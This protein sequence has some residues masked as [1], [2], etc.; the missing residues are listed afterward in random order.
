MKEPSHHP[1]KE[2]WGSKSRHL[3]HVKIA[4][5]LT[6]S[7]AIYR[8]I[9][10]ARELIRRGATIYPVM[11]EEAAELLSPTLMEWATDSRTYVRFAGE[12]G[13]IGIGEEASAMLIAPATANIIGKLASSIADNAVTLTALN[14]MGKGK[15][16]I[17]VPAMHSGLWNSRPLQEALTKLENYWAIVIPPR[18]EEG[19][20]KYPNIEDIVDAADTLSTRGQDLKGLKILVTAG[21]TREWLDPVR[22]IS[23]PSTGRMGIALAREAHFR[24]ASVT[25]I[26]GPTAESL[27]HYIKTVRVETTEEMLNAVLQKARQ[28][29]PDAVIMAAAP[30]DFRPQE[31]VETKIESGKELM[32]KLIP[33]P[34]IASTLR[35]EYGGIIIGFA[36][37][38]ILNDEERLVSKAKDKLRKR[39]FNAIIANEVSYDKVGFAAEHSKAYLITE[40]G[41]VLRI[42]KGLKIVIARK[43]L[44][45]VKEEASK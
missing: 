33:T 2:I 30:A 13:H 29:K 38:T 15:P 40:E 8:T 21:P 17:L 23:N 27:P 28:V 36:A 1:A 10:V 25:L 19:K 14:I 12:T 41:K 39:G 24:G 5:G 6:A 26:H 4:V 18:I 9:D 34:K 44:D 42:G 22:Y 35:K 43:I 7:V 32:L 20:A 3:T 37:E 16:L 45:Y 11:T 31:T